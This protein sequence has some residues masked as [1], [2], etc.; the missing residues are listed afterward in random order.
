[1]LAEGL[2]QMAMGTPAAVYNGGF[3]Q[4]HLFYYDPKRRR[5]GLPEHVA[6]LCSRATNDSAALHMVNTDPVEAHSVLLQAGAFG[7]HEF[8]EVA[9]DGSNDPTQ[10]IAV[11]GKHIKIDLAP[12]AQARLRLGLRRF[13]HRPTYAVPAYDG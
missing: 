1:M 9:V 5:P 6:A 10:R 8:T 3:L 12:G 7:E 13:V 2:I 4:T 11:N